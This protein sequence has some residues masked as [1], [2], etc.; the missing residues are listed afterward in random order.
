VLSDLHYRDTG[1]AQ[2]T[3]AVV[4]HLSQ[5]RPRP[6]FCVL[7]GDLTEDGAPGQL[8]AVKRAFWGLPFPVHALPGNHD[9]DLEGSFENYRA[10]Y[11]LTLN[12]RFSVAG[13][14]FLVLDSTEGRKVY[15][16]RVSRE[17]LEWLEGQLASLPRERPVTLFTHLPLGK[18]WLRPVNAE[19]VL[20]LFAHH[21]LEGVFSGHWHGLTQ[22]RRESALL[23]TGRCAS[24][25]RRNHDGSDEKGYLLCEVRSGRL[26]YRFVSV[27]RP[28]EDGLRLASPTPGLPGLSA[29]CEPGTNSAPGA[30]TH[31]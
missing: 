15:R 30:G 17:S 31:G 21:R 29:G 16:A 13:R 18:N 26:S 7:A 22:T 14:E 2:W 11:G 4:A 28:G 25:W 19:A 27:G 6:A 23:V 20:R 24:R 3:A 5:L 1:C 8:A 9:C 10:V 12:Y